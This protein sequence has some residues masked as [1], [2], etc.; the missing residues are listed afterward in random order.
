VYYYLSEIQSY[1]IS[2]YLI[3]SYYSSIE[4][5]SLR[6]SGAICAEFKYHMNG[7]NMGRLVVFTSNTGVDGPFFTRTEASGNEWIQGRADANIDFGE[8]VS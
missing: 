3:L 8:R 6:Y 7:G 5:P 2:S 1:L 4:T